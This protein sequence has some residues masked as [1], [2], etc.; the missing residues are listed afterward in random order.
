MYLIIRNM[1][2]YVDTHAR[3]CV[4]VCEREKEREWVSLKM[5][6]TR[7]C[8]ALKLIMYLHGNFTLKK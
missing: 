6:H 1:N 4:S 7:I 3:A 2:L 5:I 8:V